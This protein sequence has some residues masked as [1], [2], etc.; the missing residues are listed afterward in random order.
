MADVIARSVPHRKSGKSSPATRTARSCSSVSGRQTFRAWNGAEVEITG[1]G[2]PPR[3]SRGARQKCANRAD[4]ENM[5]QNESL[6]VVYLDKSASIQPR[7]SPDILKDR[8]EKCFIFFH[9]RG[10]RQRGK[11]LLWAWKKCLRRD[12]SPKSVCLRTYINC[13]TC[14]PQ[15][16][17]Q[18]GSQVGQLEI[19]WQR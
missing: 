3:K 17:H 6:E 11:M 9:V 2:E 8:Y 13:L 15:R 10:K 12:S 5:L 18:G 4:I 19:F 16:E 7:T 1:L 14:S